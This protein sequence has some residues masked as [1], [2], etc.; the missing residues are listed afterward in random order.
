MPLT[1]LFVKETALDLI[2]GLFPQTGPPKGLGGYIGSFARWVYETYNSYISSNQN[3]TS[4][5]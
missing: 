2:Y 5:P 4:C 3:S 1:N